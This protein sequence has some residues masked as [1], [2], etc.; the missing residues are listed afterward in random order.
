MTGRAHGSTLTH[1]GRVSTR[2]PGDGWWT[3]FSPGPR[4]RRLEACPFSAVPLLRAPADAAP[5]AGGLQD[6]AWVFWAVLLLPTLALLVGVSVRRVGRD[7]LVLSSGAGG[8]PG[9][10]RPGSWRGCP[11]S[12]A[13]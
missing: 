5:G 7:E 1:A 10:G 4:R 13:S 8:W 2:R 11:A 9:R 3:P 6:G 12:S